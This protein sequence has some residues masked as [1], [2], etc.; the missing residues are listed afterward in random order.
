MKPMLTACIILT[1][2][3]VA[4]TL[5]VAYAIATGADEQDAA[6]RVTKEIIN[7]P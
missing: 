6:V 4:I 2:V 5:R 3:L 7:K 1:G